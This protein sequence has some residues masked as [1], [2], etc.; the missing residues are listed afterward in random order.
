M[1]TGIVW[2]AANGENQIKRRAQEG[3][4][5]KITAT[6]SP[7]RE[8]RTKVTLLLDQSAHLALTVH[9]SAHGKLAALFERHDCVDKRTM[10]LERATMWLI[11]RRSDAA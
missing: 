10:A 7:Y 3:K 4:D 6:G 9:R 8:S 5:K 1:F 2:N 11:G